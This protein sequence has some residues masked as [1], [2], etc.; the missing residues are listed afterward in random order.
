[1]I[2]NLWKNTH[3]YCGHRHKEP[4]EMYFKDGVAGNSMFYACP[5]YYPENREE[6]ER[7]CSNRLNFVDAEGIINKLSD[8]IE[9]KE[10]S[11]EIFDF[12]NLKFRYKAIDVKVLSYSPSKV[13]LEIVNKK[14]LR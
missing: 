12:T 10:M 13:E 3:F 14:A 5:K 8:I 9:E 11:G 1:M 2:K 6:G 7:A 4:V